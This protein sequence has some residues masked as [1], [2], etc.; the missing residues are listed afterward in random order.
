MS[1]P[2]RAL[3][4]L[5]F[6]L[7]VSACARRVPETVAEP[8]AGVNVRPTGLVDVA[9]LDSAA[10]ARRRALT[11]AGV[12]VARNEAGYYVDVLEARARQLSSEGFQIERRDGTLT[13]RLGASAAFP[14][15]SARLSEPAR[16][17]LALVARVLRHYSA[18]L[19]TVFGHTDD[20]GDASSNQLLSEQR[21]LAV[22]HALTDGGVA[23]QR[24]LAV[25]MGSRE[26]LAPNTTAAGRERNRRVELR[27]EVVQ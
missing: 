11:E 21:A 9:A 22:L 15:G 24:L 20:S 19:V 25:G 27:V 2:G 10:A 26:P 17:S 5:F 18:S 6:F 3:T 4:L 14:V 1:G 7:L 8:A 12:R 23:P 13:L 16:Q